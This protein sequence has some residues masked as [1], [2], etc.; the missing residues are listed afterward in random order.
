M[1][2]RLAIED[3]VRA[4]LPQGAGHMGFIGFSPFGDDYH[5]L[6]PVDLE[7]ARVLSA[8]GAGGR[9]GDL[10]S[11]GGRPGWRYLPCR[12]YQTP[13]SCAQGPPERQA[14]ILARRAQ[15]LFT[16]GQ[17]VGWAK[18]QGWWADLVDEG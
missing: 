12:T 8:A 2:L 3:L 14:F 13:P 5:L 7:R 4:T 18:R 9:D 6:V 11:L 15:A 16:A 1:A 17:I 10:V